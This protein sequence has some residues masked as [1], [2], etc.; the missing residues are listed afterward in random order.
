MIPRVLKHLILECLKIIPVELPPCLADLIVCDRL[1]KKRFMTGVMRLITAFRI[2]SGSA[3][4]EDVKDEV[5]FFA[6]VQAAIRK[7]DAVS[8]A[9]RAVEDTEFAISQ[10]INRAVGST[11]VIDILK[12]CG[13]A[14]PDIGM[15]D[16]AFL[17]GI[18]GIDQKNLAIEA[19]RRLL[20]DEIATRTRTNLAKKDAFSLQLTEAIARYHNRSVDALQV[21]QELLKLARDLREEPEDGLSQEEA[22]FYDALARSE[23]AVALMGNEDLRIIAAELVN[24]VRASASVD[25]WRKDNVRTKMRVAV[26]RILKKHGFPPDLQDDAIKHVVQQAEAMAREMS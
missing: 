13:V 16:E 6:A 17:L 22:A 12:E 18:Q 26:K 20:N 24:V 2:A 9:G 11:E 25:W 10:L 5:G 7:L 14:R 8:S 15:L 4:A 23:S 21:I 1:S 3:E 19:L